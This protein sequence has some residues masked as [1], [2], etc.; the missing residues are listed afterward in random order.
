M[1]MV[2]N[3]LLL[4][5][6]GS[7]PNMAHLKISKHHYIHIATDWLAGGL[8]AIKGAVIYKNLVGSY[9][10]HAFGTAA[11]GIGVLFVAGF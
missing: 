7:N 8:L 4:N 2:C 6:D 5:Y 11:I 10:Y 9:Y 1:G 3:S